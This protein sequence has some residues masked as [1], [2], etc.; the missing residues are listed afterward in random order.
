MRIDFSRMIT[1]ERRRL[2]DERMRVLAAIADTQ[3]VLAQSDWM[4]IRAAEGGAP[5]SEAIRA[6]RADARTRISSLREELSHLPADDA[7]P[8]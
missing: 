1:A 6:S 2:Q 8:A 7:P 4:V 3:Q 5:L